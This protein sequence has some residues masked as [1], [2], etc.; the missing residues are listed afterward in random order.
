[1]WSS[2]ELVDGLEPHAR[3]HTLGPDADVGTAVRWGGGVPGV[4]QRLGSREG[5]YRVLIQVRSRVNLAIWTLDLIE[6]VHTA[7]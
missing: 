2:S 6:S 1:M 4:V 5:L 3:L 7:V